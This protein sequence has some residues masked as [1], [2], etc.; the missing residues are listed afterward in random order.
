[1]NVRH[2]QLVMARLLLVM[3]KVLMMAGQL[4]ACPSSQNTEKEPL[5]L[6]QQYAKEAV[7]GH[8]AATNALDRS[9]AHARAATT[10]GFDQSR[11]AAATY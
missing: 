11:L 3:P 10:N 6:L 9:F 1:M 2:L 5:D 8:V 7:R 4:L